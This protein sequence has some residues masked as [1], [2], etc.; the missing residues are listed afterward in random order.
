MRRRQGARAMGPQQVDQLAL[1]DD[2]GA[3]RFHRAGDTFVDLHVEACAAQSEPCAEPADGT[4]PMRCR[5]LLL[6]K[7]RSC[8][9]PFGRVNLGLRHEELVSMAS[10]HL[11]VTM[12]L[13]PNDR[14][15]FELIS[16][17]R[18]QS[19]NRPLDQ[20][21]ESGVASPRNRW[22]IWRRPERKAPANSARELATP[23]SCDW[24]NGRFPGSL[25]SKHPDC[26]RAFF[27]GRFSLRRCRFGRLR[28]NGR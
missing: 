8:R 12:C 24:L 26:G 19:R 7:P 20:S 16:T 17:L 18:G 13:C 21:Q 25:P 27:G 3:A 11:S 4:A 15:Q 1:H 9:A 5:T 10:S 14:K 28:P 23:N 6:P 2:A 22:A